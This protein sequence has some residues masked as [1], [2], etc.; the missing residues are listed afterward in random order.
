MSKK[1]KYHFDYDILMY[2]LT[3]RYLIFSEYK[4]STMY[5]QGGSEKRYLFSRDTGVVFVYARGTKDMSVV[6]PSI[7]VE[8]RNIQSF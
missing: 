6:F 4:S 7:N 5:I 1:F 2:S 8:K 3:L